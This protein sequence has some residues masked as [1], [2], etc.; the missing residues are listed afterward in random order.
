[1]ETGADTDFSGYYTLSGMVSGVY[2]LELSYVGYPTHRITGVVVA[3]GHGFRLDLNLSSEVIELS[4]VVVMGYKVPLVSQDAMVT[5]AAIQR[6]PSNSA[7]PMAASLE[8]MGS[9]DEGL[10]VMIKGSRSEATVYFLDGIRVSGTLVEAMDDSQVKSVEVISGKNAAALFGPDVAGDVVLI[11]TK[12]GAKGK[13]FD[14]EFLEGASGPN[15]FGTIFPTMP[16]GSPL[17]DQPRGQGQ[18]SGHLSRRHHPLANLRARHDR[19]RGKAAWARALLVRS[20]PWRAGSACRAFWWK[21]I[22]SSP[23]EKSSTMSP[24]PSKSRVPCR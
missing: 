9:G 11:T 6:I 18:F 13:A 5:S 7:H 3:P 16:F 10:D 4:T 15:P 8:V 19:Q 17:A 1:M 14:P 24:T 2:D 20:S 23:S 12:A 22:P 21:E